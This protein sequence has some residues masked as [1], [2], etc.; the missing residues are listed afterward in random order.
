MQCKDCAA[1]WNVIDNLLGLIAESRREIIK[2]RN[3]FDNGS[4]DITVHTRCMKCGEDE[5]Q[6]ICWST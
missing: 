5:T 6:C 3:T 4:E 1:I 2:L